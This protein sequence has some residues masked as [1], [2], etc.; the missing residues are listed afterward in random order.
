VST[1]TA[2]VDAM[3]PSKPGST[4]TA[5]PRPPDGF[6]SKGPYRTYLAFGSGGIFLLLVA[7]LLLRAIWALGNGE[8]E[9][10]GV[11]ASFQHPLYVIFHL[12]AFGWL[13]WFALRFFKLF[14]KTQ[15]F[16]AGAIKRPPD[17]VVFAAL[18][19]A[20]FAASAIVVAILW[21]AIL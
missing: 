21:G 4:R 12:I 17:P 10:N 15:P 9:W 11:M 6:P 3:K 5:P 19:G 2:R 14:P 20:F 7:V 16:R 18:A 8:A 1:S 13:T